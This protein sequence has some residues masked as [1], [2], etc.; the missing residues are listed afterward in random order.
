MQARIVVAALV[1]VCAQ[2][3]AGKVLNLDESNFNEHV[4]AGN[5]GVF[6]K[7]FAPWCGHCKQM[8]PAWEKLGEHFSES[9]TVLIAEVDCT[10]E[11][12]KSLC[13]THGVR[14]FPSL[15]FTGSSGSLEDYSGGRDFEALS[16]FANTKVTCRPV[17]CRS[18]A[19]PFI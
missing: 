15:K 3:G 10:A 18:D 17:L 2:A 13:E 19:R 9:E 14:G 12:A 8:A 16:E 4:V 7:F 11:S 6:I 1:L 5:K